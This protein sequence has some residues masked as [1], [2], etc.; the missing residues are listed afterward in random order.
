[1]RFGATTIAYRALAVLFAIFS[2]T[3]VAQTPSEPDLRGRWIVDVPGEPE[4]RTLVIAE[5]A[6]TPDGA[7]LAARYGLTKSGQG[8]IE[9]RMIRTESGRQLRFTTQASTVVA[10]TE[11]PDGSFKGTFARKNGVVDAVI[12]SR[13]PA[14]AEPS[15]LAQKTDTLA[16]IPP[17]SSVPSECSAFHGTWSGT[18]SQ[19][20]FAEQ[21]LRVHE[22]SSTGDGKCTARLSY[23]S[24]KSPILPNV[25]AEFEGGKLSF[26]CNRST[27]GT[28]VFRASGDVLWANY[29]NSAGGTNSA[30]FTRATQ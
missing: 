10:V 23:S 9:A 24:S 29:S 12:I 25:K 19:G 5:V 18:W 14:L 27:G 28:C 4:T 30:R 2:A 15:A 7:L 22:V 3:A 1:M 20:G 16:F 13:A 6:P 26:V 21:F 8:P 11:Q 17:A